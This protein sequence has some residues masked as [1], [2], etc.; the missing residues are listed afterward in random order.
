M[1]RPNDMYDL[2]GRVITSPFLQDCRDLVMRLR[3]RT[4]LWNFAHY[5]TLLEHW[6]SIYIFTPELAYSEDYIVYQ[7]SLSLLLIF[8]LKCQ[9]CHQKEHLF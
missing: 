9:S 3:G 4:I 2:V 1:V 6:R 5:I 8:K 7:V